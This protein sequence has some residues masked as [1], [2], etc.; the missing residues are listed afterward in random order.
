MENEYDEWLQLGCDK[1]K[2]I[3]EEMEKENN[4]SQKK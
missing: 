1:A 2:K 4:D 3:I